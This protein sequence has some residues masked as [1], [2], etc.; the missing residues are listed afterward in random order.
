[1]EKFLRE[2]DLQPRSLEIVSR[3]GKNVIATRMTEF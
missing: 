3:G 1:M 2:I